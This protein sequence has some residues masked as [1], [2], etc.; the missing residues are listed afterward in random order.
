M[1]FLRGPSAF[2][3][4]HLAAGFILATSLLGAITA[5]W[6]FPPGYDRRALTPRRL[7]VP[8]VVVRPS[9]LRLI[10]KLTGRA[11]LRRVRR[12]EMPIGN[13]GIV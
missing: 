7:R 2:L 4:I 11:V 6:K 13:V 8:M 3:P 12:S 10:P 1:N 5:L 9:A